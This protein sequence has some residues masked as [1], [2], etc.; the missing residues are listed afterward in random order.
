MEYSIS[1]P[2]TILLTG[3]TGFIGSHVLEALVGEGHT[4]CIVVRESSDTRRIDHLLDHPQIKRYGDSILELRRLFMEQTIDCVFHLA[5]KYIKFHK[6]TEEVEDLVNSNVTFPSVLLD[7]MREYGVK[8]IITTGTFFEYDLTRNG[9]LTE[10]SPLKPYNFYARTKL[11]FDDV[12]RDYA[13]QYGMACVHFRLFAPYGPKDNEK[14]IPCIIQ[15]FLAGQ[16]VQLTPGEQQWNFT[17]VGDIVEAYM[18]ALEFLFNNEA[19]KSSSATSWYEVFNIGQTEVMSIR[20]LVETVEQK[21]GVT[22]LV[23]FDKPYPPDEIF[24]AACDGKKALEKLGWQARTS[25]EEGLEKTIN[26]YRK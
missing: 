14:L 10:T 16:E 22:G 13:E 11:M 25:I 8:K 1:M 15:K 2:R 24:F 21:L 9:V 6:T 7:L 20:K 17:Y 23:K 12:A 3:A 26:F 19:T 5:T 18:A 4:V